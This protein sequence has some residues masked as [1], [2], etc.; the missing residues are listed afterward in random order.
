MSERRLAAALGYP[1]GIADNAI[2]TSEPEDSYG[3][4]PAIP[5]KLNIRIAQVTSH[6]LSDVYCS[7]PADKHELT[8]RVV[9]LLRD[10]HSI[11]QTIPPD[12][13]FEF[14][15]S[16]KAAQTSRSRLRTSASL[17]L[18]LYQAVVLTLRPILLHLAKSAWAHAGEPT[19]EPVPTSM[20]KLANTCMS[21]A[22]N[23]LRVLGVLKEQDMLSAFGF[24]DIESV[25]AAAFVMLLFNIVMNV[26]GDASDLQPGL[27]ISDALEILDYLAARGN[28]AAAGRKTEIM[29]V[30]SLLSMQMPGF[31]EVR[32][33]PVTEDTT[34]ERDALNRG[35]SDPDVLIEQPCSGADASHGDN[36]HE[37]SF[38]GLDAWANDVALEDY[39]W[40]DLTDMNAFPSMT[41]PML[42]LED[43][44]RYILS[45]AKVDLGVGIYRNENGLYHEYGA[46]KEAK[47]V[48]SDW[49][50]GHDYEVTIGKPSFLNLA[51]GLLFF[52]DS[53]AVESGRIA[54]VQTI[55]GTGACHLGATFLS[56]FNPTSSRKAFVGVPAWGNYQPLLELAGI[57][58]ENY[59]YY[60]PQSKRVDFSSIIRAVRC[61]PE[62]S[63]FVLQACCHNPTGADLTQ[64]Q[65]Q[66]LS[67]ELSRKN[68]V[69]FFDIAYHGLGNS[70]DEDAFAI[71]HFTDRGF[72]MM[73]ARA[74]E[75]EDTTQ[76]LEAKITPGDWTHIIEEKGLF[77]F[78]RLSAEQCSTLISRYHIYLP[79][80]GRINVA[81]LND[82]NIRRV[83]ECISVVVKENGIED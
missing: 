28:K 19:T 69:P 49:N 31:G 61:A 74:A 38:E 4:L 33:P 55:S 43:L 81:G 77:G 65:W 80:T 35:A 39:I 78:L 5:I 53:E 34:N 6:V 83:A 47:K 9:A 20:H 27:G 54:S 7:T 79:S 12:L 70:L 26:F 18:M 30:T 23:I 52:K 51:A 2:T 82:K 56:R 45:P 75:Y 24:F 32:T 64:S 63:I 50:P 66:D 58:V 59:S 25:F 37:Y 42:G 76:E 46:I 40:S 68:H 15:Q 73:G 71:R 16:P 44:E 21:A 57:A 8:S 11:T 48:L 14:G 41:D 62:G 17:H 67:V 10:I 3:F 60:D 29:R 1:L 36:A 22:Q 13:V 72:E